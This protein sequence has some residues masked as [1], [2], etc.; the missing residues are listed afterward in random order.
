MNLK[1]DFGVLPS[2]LRTRFIVYQ[3]ALRLVDLWW[4]KGIRPCDKFDS[5]NNED[6][7]LLKDSKY[8]DKNKYT[9][10]INN[11]NR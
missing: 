1:D 5:K 10:S 6:Y 3:H 2:I 8:D 7:I 9:C 11:C 4:D